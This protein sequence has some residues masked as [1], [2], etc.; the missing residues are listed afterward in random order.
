M[1]C[2]PWFDLTD[3]DLVVDFGNEILDTGLSPMEHQRQ[4]AAARDIATHPNGGARFVYVGPRLSQTGSNSDEWLAARPGSEGILALALARVVIES[5]GGTEQHQA[6]LNGVLADADVDSVSAKTDLP[7]ETISRLGRALANAGNPVAIPPGVAVSTRRAIATTAAVLILNDVIGA[8]GRSVRIPPEGEPR[9]RASY[10]DVLAL[11]KAI[12]EERVGVLLVHDSNPVYSLPKAAGF[13]AALA[14]VPFVVSFA[15]MVDETAERAHLILPDHTPLESWGDLVPRDGVRCLIQPTIRPLWDTRALGDTLLDAARAMGEEVASK[16]PPGSFRTVLEEAWSGTDLAAALARGGEFSQPAPA[17]A[18]VALVEGA[19]RLEVVEPVFSGEGDFVL[20]P[21]PHSFLYD[22]RGANL[23][24]LQEIP[25]PVVSVTWE[26]WAEI[27]LDTAERLGLELGDVVAVETSAGR[28][29]A[30]GPSARW[31]PRRRGGGSHRTGSQRRTLCLPRR[32]RA[33]G[34]GPRRQRDRA[35]SRRSR[36]ER[37]PGLAD[38]E[39]APSQDRSLPA[40]AAASVL[41]QQAGSPARRSHRAGGPRRSGARRAMES[42]V[43]T[44]HHGSHEIREEFQAHR[45]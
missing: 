15:S 5:G 33:G 37:W 45:L 41:G 34:R 6:L 36:R 25:D 24:W 20:L 23:P 7:A 39:R 17:T 21:F 32:R 8:V 31:H 43:E 18:P 10:R 12:E 22:G 35:A 30:F 9:R 4:L 28:A 44:E 1:D 2:E 38:R 40:S 14:K 3:A 19:G 11:V 26:P 29:R 27:S 42:Q 13:E 16:L